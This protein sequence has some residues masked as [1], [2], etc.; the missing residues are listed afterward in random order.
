MSDRVEKPFEYSVERTPTGVNLTIERE[1]I[2]FVREVIPDGQMAGMM[3]HR[4]VEGSEEMTFDIPLPQARA[5]YEQ[6]G[7]ALGERRP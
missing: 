2:N 4:P 1:I 6:L 3:G 5:L 7:R